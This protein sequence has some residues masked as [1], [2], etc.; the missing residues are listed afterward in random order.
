MWHSSIRWIVGGFLLATP[1][2]AQAQSD[3][4]IRAAILGGDKSCSLTGMKVVHR[5][6]LPG[7]AQ[8]VAVAL[9]GVEGCGG[10][11]MT[12]STFGVFV[13]DRGR[14]RQLPASL[15]NGPEVTQK[16][17]VQ[18]GRIVVSGLSYGPRDPRCCPTLPRTQRFVMQGDQ[19]VPVR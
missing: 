13:A 1:I 6:P 4:A 15:V 14:S 5:G 16:V 18:D 3:S 11:N 2:A 17:A 9:Y 12:V 19:V 8:P 7:A 10:G